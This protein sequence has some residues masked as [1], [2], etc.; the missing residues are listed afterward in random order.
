MVGR[1]SDL[2][3]YKDIFSSRDF[4]RILAGGALIPVGFYLARLGS[5]DTGLARPE[6]GIPLPSGE[7]L[8]NML[9]ILSVA[10]NGLPIVFGALKGI[11]ARKVNVDEL[12]SIAIVAC[13]LNGNLIEAALI[14]LIMVVGAFVEE[15]V[16]DRARGAIASLVA[17]TPQTALVDSSGR[18]IR[19]PISEVRIGDTVVVK[20]G[21]MV[22]VDGLILDGEASVDESLLTGEPIP[23]FRSSGD[24]ACAGT[25]NLD[26][27]IRLMVRKTGEDATLGRIV[28][29]IQKA[30]N[31]QVGR[32]RIVDRYAAWFTPIILS[33]AA[34][35][36]GITGDISRA[37]AVLVVGCPCSFLLAGPVS[38]VAAVGRAARSGILVKGGQHLEDLARAKVFFFDKTGT[39]TTGRP[40]V[41]AIRPAPGNNKRQVLETAASVEHGSTHPI[42]EAI[43][44]WALQTGIEGRRADNISVIPGC[45][46]K[47]EFAGKTVFVT[48]GE[49]HTDEGHTVV[50]VIVDNQ[51][52]GKIIL[53]DKARSEARETVRRLR[54]L[55]VE[56]IAIV[57]GDGEAAVRKI[58]TELDLSDYHY[59][60]R[61]EEKQALL[62]TAGF[63]GVVFAGD[64]I[65]DAPSLKAA[66]VGI[67][68]GRRGSRMALDT[69]DIV[70]MNDKISLLPFLV[71]LSRKMARIIK[72]DI[73]LSLIFNAVAI[74][75][76][77]MGLLSPIMGAVAHNIGSIVVVILSFSIALTR[78][79]PT[80]TE[81]AN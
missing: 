8:F 4:A 17:A 14:S 24:E 19:R 51:S 80:E 55:G 27:R 15:A 52:I 6:L 68:M 16:S 81:R 56:K 62:N 29:L 60:Q 37:I 11:V 49:L 57:S 30:E 26:G 69:A 35:T 73:T 77:T 38:T 63:E 71:R 32:A 10:I 1:F 47:G 67:A 65:N 70:L 41:T 59:R 79:I 58:A 40:V 25:L 45:G 2:S 74:V 46:V 39:L 48:A 5:P 20:A 9:L 12:V 18:E 23:V 64:G 33:I 13:L 7:A 76:S 36:Y 61:P 44:Q 31:S 54:A 42:A 21:E 3:V 75:L 78:E 22:P 43:L 53:L 72:A 34:A 66:E 28:H 50:D